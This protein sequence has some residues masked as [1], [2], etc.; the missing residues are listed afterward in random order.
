M[1]DGNGN[2][3]AFS[4]AN[5]AGRI[6]ACIEIINF[7]SDVWSVRLPLFIDNAESIVKLA[8]TETQIIQLIVSEKDKTLRLA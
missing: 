4:V 6:N 7:L 3:I 8:D 2:N 1:S 5:N